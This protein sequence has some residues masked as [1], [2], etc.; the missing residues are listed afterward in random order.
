MSGQREGAEAL[1]YD[2]EAGPAEGD[3]VQRSSSGGIRQ[4][5]LPVGGDD[6]GCYTCR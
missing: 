3:P 5:A 2:D 1:P 6:D 4:Q